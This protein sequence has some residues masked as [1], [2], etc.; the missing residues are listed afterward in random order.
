MSE[1]IIDGL[2]DHLKPLESFLGS[3]VLLTG[4][5]LPPGLEDRHLSAI[6]N[7]GSTLGFV[8]TPNPDSCA[9][10]AKV[11]AAYLRTERL[12]REA[13]SLQGRLI[14]EI[15]VRTE[16]EEALRFME[17]KALQ[18]QVNPHFL[19]N[20]L[21]TIAGL[22][23]FEDAP[24]T[25]A[26]LMALARL[27]R[28]SLRMIGQSVSLQEELNNVTDYLAIQGARFGDRIKVEIC[29]EDEARDAQIP[30]LTLQP[31]VENAIIHGL[32][33]LEEGF[34]S[35]QARV[36]AGSVII[37]VADSGVGIAEE[38]LLAIEQAD[39]EGTGRGH[40]TGIGLGNVK[41]RLQHFFGSGTVCQ[42]QSVPGEGTRVRLVVPYIN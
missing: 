28:Y 7:E 21:A 35:L 38:R 36:E 23:L 31:L 18:S 17:L 15:R 8:C 9:A 26:L 33:S 40:T 22:A 1:P 2:R 19:F 13:S 16:L 27:L 11:I 3:Y 30:V 5:G 24:E 37:V 39:Q 4:E 20:T 12:Q 41:K 32:E 14:E 10:Y 6:E 29:V 25:N 42:L 34:L